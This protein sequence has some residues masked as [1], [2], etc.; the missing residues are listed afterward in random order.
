MTDSRM[1][2]MEDLR[3]RIERDEYSVDA[4]KVADAIVARLLAGRSAKDDAK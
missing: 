4:S 3:A 1:S 2:K